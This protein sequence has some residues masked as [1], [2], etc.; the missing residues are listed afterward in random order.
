[1]LATKQRFSRNLYFQFHPLHTIFS[2]V[3]ALLL[4]GML[5]WFLAIPAR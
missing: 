3:G 4:F 1:M 5:V 2:V